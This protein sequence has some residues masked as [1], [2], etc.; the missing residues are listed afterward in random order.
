MRTFLCEFWAVISAFSVII[1]VISFI[2]TPTPCEQLQDRFQNKRRLLL[3][4]ISM[5]ICFGAYYVSRTSVRVPG[6]EG[7]SVSEARQTLQESELFAVVGSEIEEETAEVKRQ[8]PEVGSYAAVGSKVYLFLDDGILDEIETSQI[9]NSTSSDSVSE[10]EAFNAQTML[11]SYVIA[12]TTKAMKE[13]LVNILSNPVPFVDSFTSNKT[14]LPFYNFSYDEQDSI[15]ELIEAVVGQDDEMASLLQE[16][17]ISHTSYEVIRTFYKGYKIELHRSAYT[18]G[19]TKIE[20]RPEYG[21]SYYLSLLSD[22][23]YI[24]GECADWNWNGEFKKVTPYYTSWGSAK[25]GRI[26]GVRTSQYT[27]GTIKQD[28]YQNGYCDDP[29]WESTI[30]SPKLGYMMS[31]EMF[32]SIELWN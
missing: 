9:I 17:R 30:S 29:L 25:D 31:E 20:L 21:T 32:N 13:K 7:S 4:V 11:Q 12:S 2:F 28:I 16:F 26:H 10:K 5:A 18:R 22:E 1:A 27:D 19:I 15:K 23:T 8:D 24:K 14:F 6:V 3:V